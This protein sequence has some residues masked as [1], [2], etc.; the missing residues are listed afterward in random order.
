M[1]HG[2]LPCTCTYHQD[3]LYLCVQVIASQQRMNRISHE[4]EH[5]LHCMQSDEQNN[6]RRPPRVLIATALWIFQTGSCHV[7]VKLQIIG[8]LC[9]V[10]DSSFKTT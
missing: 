1:L 10:Y 6:M 7:V 8:F 3:T 9:K 2:V 5:A 4:Q